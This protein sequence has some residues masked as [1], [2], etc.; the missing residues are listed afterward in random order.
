MPVA[1]QPLIVDL[2]RSA[3][4]LSSPMGMVP[5]W[6]PR[7]R[8]RNGLQPGA[9]PAPGCLRCSHP[10]RD[11]LPAAAM[12]A[13]PLHAAGLDTPVVTVLTQCVVSPRDPAM[14]HPAN[15]SVLSIHGLTPRN[16]KR[17][18]GWQ[19]VEDAARGI[20]VSYPLRI[21]RRSWNWK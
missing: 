17:I 13:Q 4:T 15:P 14:T 20:A 12:P 18:F 16:A 21:P 11:W 2:I 8:D 7:C 10:G 1:P 3:I 9:Q 19:I 6:A 5:R